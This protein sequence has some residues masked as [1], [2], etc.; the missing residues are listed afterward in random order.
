M[1]REYVEQAYLPASAAARRRTADGCAE[2]KALAAW[3]EQLSQ[4]WPGLHAGSA[5]AIE[6]D[7]VW[8]VSV[9]VSLGEVQGEEVAVQ[10]YA[11]PNGDFPGEAIAMQQERAIP[12]AV[13]GFIYNCQLPAIAPRRRLHGARGPAR[14]GA[15]L[16]AELPLDCLAALGRS[17]VREAA[18]RPAW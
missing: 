4:R 11:D 2:A 17:P 1:V 5:T 15:H 6:S 12:G 8:N 3:A 16:P 18:P 7:G 13:N 10:L 9:P 14:A